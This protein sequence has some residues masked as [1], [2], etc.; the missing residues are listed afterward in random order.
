MLTLI[1]AYIVVNGATIPLILFMFAMFLDVIIIL[2][3]VAIIKTD[4]NGREE[5]GTE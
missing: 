2:G 5:N 4:F 3:A 1:L